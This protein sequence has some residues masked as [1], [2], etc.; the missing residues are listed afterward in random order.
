MSGEHPLFDKGATVD[1]FTYSIGTFLT[2]IL[3][4]GNPGQRFDNSKFFFFCGGSVF[5]DMNG[6]SKYILDTEAS[7]KLR[8]YYQNDFEKEIKENKSWQHIYD[9]SGLG[10]AFRSMM[11]FPYLKQ[12]HNGLFSGY[13]DRLMAAVLKHDRVV[14]PDA[15][16]KV[17]K[18]NIVTEFDFEYKYIHENP[19][20]LASSPAVAEKVNIAFNKVINKAVAFLV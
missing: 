5:E 7:G 20:P 16:R 17:L 6:I 1:F 4:L 13:K 15:V 18:N 9:G 10:N 11:S 14:I 19:F 3:M 8:D 2:Q 12:A